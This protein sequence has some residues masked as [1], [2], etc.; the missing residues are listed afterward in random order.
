MFPRAHFKS[1]PAV[2][3]RYGFTILEILVASVILCVLLAMIF[4]AT[5]SINKTVKHASSKMDAFA[6]ARSG[7]DIMTQKLSQAT[8]N[9]YWDYYDANGN[10]RS[11]TNNS[12]FVADRY[13]RA[14]D[15]QFIVAKN[16]Q[17]S[18]YGQAVFFQAP[19]NEASSA[20]YRS[21]QGLL[22]A[23]GFFVQYSSDDTFRASV[24]STPKWRF[25]LMQCVQPT[26][27]LKI[28][29]GT[30]VF[31]N[32]GTSWT[33]S[34]PDSSVDE[35]T[36]TASATPLAE[37]VIALIVWPRLPLASDTA[38]TQ[39]TTDYQYDSQL[40]ANADPQPVTADQLPPSLQVTIVAIDEASASRIET[41]SSTP[42]SIIADA[43]RGKF[44]DVTLYQSDLDKLGSALAAKK[45]TFQILNTSVA[46]LESKWSITP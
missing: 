11:A 13:A 29:S 17:N 34:I 18:D 15:L 35:T 42:P 5:E 2:W 3:A 16:T 10:R 30:S 12:T 23:C 33:G 27:N 24:V 21:V 44:T 22:N 28:F 8:V 7:F 45:I 25:R 32:Y 39:L 31:N 40:N 20:N 43:L 4:T 9:T 38:G 37:N 1:C 46:L 26:E 14:S 19:E 36:V 41:N 6:A